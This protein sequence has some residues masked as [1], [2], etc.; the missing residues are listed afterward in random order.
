MPLRFAQLVSLIPDDYISLSVWSKCAIA[1]DT[2]FFMTASLTQ[3]QWRYNT[4]TGDY[5]FGIIW[6]YIS[7]QLEK[8][9]IVPLKTN[10]MRRKNV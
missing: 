10:S 3:A 2:S 1:L 8:R 4:I 5:N 6:D 7:T 9:Y